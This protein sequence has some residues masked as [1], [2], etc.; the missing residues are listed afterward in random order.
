[1]SFCIGAI[2]IEKDLAHILVTGTLS[3]QHQHDVFHVMFGY[4]LFLVILDL[5]QPQRQPQ[6]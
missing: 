2:F 5:P 4:I 6:H 1:M 3:G